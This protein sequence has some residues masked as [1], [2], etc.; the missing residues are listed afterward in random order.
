MGLEGIVLF[1]LDVAH[2]LLTDGD[3]EAL[4]N[5]CHNLAL[6][7]IQANDV[8]SLHTDAECINKQVTILL[9]CDCTGIFRQCR[10]L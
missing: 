7:G 9:V 5:C 4:A 6:N 8:T 2:V 3:P 1:R 10:H